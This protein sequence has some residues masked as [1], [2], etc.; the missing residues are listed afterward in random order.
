MKAVKAAVEDK[1]EMPLLPR[2]VTLTTNTADY[3]F[4]KFLLCPSAALRRMHI[5]LRVEVKPEFADPQARLNLPEDH[6]FRWDD[7]STFPWILSV[8][9]PEGERLGEYERMSLPAY[10]LHFRE[11]Y[12]RCTTAN[13]RMKK[14][15]QDLE[16]YTFCPGCSLI[17]TKESCSLD[18]VEAGE[19]YCEGTGE[20]VPLLS[21]APPELRVHILR[22][23][24][25]GLKDRFRK[26]PCDKCLGDIT[27]DGEQVGGLTW[28]NDKAVAQRE[29]LDAIKATTQKHWK[30]VALSGLFTTVSV[31]AAYAL[32]RRRVEEVL[33]TDPQ[34]NA[35]SY[36]HTT[37]ANCSG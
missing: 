12:Q 23:W 31:A 21:E 35:Y 7:E 8:A 15:A 6:E 33:S 20:S 11:V 9:K 4:R 2:L 16:A 3:A 30:M 22:R 26:A 14:F 37:P 24:L 5:H 17:H 13:V 27:L 25:M 10:L 34:G 18:A 28:E 32:Y 1:G 29:W 19:A 36:S